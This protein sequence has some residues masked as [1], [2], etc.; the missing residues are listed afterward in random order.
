MAIE[1]ESIAQVA[2]SQHLL[3]ERCNSLFRHLPTS[4]VVSLVIAMILSGGHWGVVGQA[5]IIAWNLILLLVLCARLILLLFWRYTQKSRPLTT[6]LALFRLGAWATGLVWGSSVFFIFSET[7]ASYQALLAFSIAGVA[8]GSLTSLTLDRWSAIG[9]V[10]CAVFPLTIKLYL[11][12]GPVALPMFS[13]SLIFVFFVLTSTS[14]SQRTLETRLIQN[15]ELVQLTEE[16]SKSQET[17]SIIR[18]AQEKFIKN[19]NG[20]SALDYI[21]EKLM[22]ISGSELGFIGKVEQ[23]STPYMKALIFKGSAAR[24]RSL[25]QYRAKHLPENGIIFNQNGLIGAALAT[26]KPVISNNLARDMRSAGTPPGHPEI[27]NFFAIPIY[28]NNDMIALLGLANSSSDYH[29][30]QVENYAPLL[31]SIAQFVQTASHEEDHARDKAALIEQSINTQIILDNIADGIIMINQ[32]GEIQTFNKAAEVI[33]G[34]RKEQVIGKNVSLLMPEPH[35]SQHNDYLESFLRTGKGSILGRGREVGGRRKNGTIFPLDLIVSNIIVNNDPY[36]IGV[37]RDISES[38]SNYM[39]ANKSS[40]Q[41]IDLLDLAYYL[42]QKVQ[43]SPDQMPYAPVAKALEQRTFQFIETYLLSERQLKFTRFELGQVIK[44][45]IDQ[46]KEK[47]NYGPSEIE[48][49]PKDEC[50]INADSLLLGLALRLLLSNY[51]SYFSDG[52]W[53]SLQS[54]QNYAKITIRPQKQT[55]SLTLIMND[56]LLLKNL[57][58]AQALNLSQVFTM[59]FGRCSVEWDNLYGPITH[60]QFPLTIGSQG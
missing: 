24:S 43:S 49:N 28:S 53:V 60:I 37:V 1:Q 42:S 14:R 27:S 50:F 59:V 39:N 29:E 2:I 32:K 47:Y 55:E 18:L 45:N 44:N 51:L 35:K 17:D 16:L 30:N 15:F 57:G 22:T 40:A 13:M 7:N 33:F 41:I 11:H 58:Q 19:K 34:Y 26:G 20:L 5:E 25:N 52:I 6:W 48:Y 31:T 46:L 10:A 8:S 3:Q 21:L 38:H 54:V 9:F 56:I 12:A 36:F 4:L 23:D